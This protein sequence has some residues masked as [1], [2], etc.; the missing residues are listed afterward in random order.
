MHHFLGQFRK[1]TLWRAISCCLLAYGAPLWAEEPMDFDPSFLM[2]QKNTNIDLERYSQGNITLPG[3]YKMVVY[4]NGAQ[5]N[6][7]ELD[8]FEIKKQQT[9]VPCISSLTL[10]QLHIKAPDTI[11]DADILLKK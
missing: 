2:G 6:N 7:L 11:T 5:A 4:L 8:F 10:S 9:A 1:K 3:H